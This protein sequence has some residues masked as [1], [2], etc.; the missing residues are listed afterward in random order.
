[1]ISSFLGYR[2]NKFCGEHLMIVNESPA[3]DPTHYPSPK[4]RSVPENASE[5]YTEEDIVED[6]GSNENGPVASALLQNEQAFHHLKI[7]KSSQSDL[8]YERKKVASVEAQEKPNKKV[9]SQVC[10]LKVNIFRYC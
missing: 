6:N 4:E 1:M 2:I 8:E 9:F 10:N 5:S 3:P 7:L